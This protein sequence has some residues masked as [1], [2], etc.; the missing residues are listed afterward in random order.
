LLSFSNDLSHH[1]KYQ[2]TQ[3][4]VWF[5][6]QIKLKKIYLIIF[7]LL[8][9]SCS[10]SSD[11]GVASLSN[12]TT[13]TSVIAEED[14]PIVLTQCLNEEM[15]YNIATPF[16]IEDLKST[17][18]QLSNSKDE[19]KQLREDVDYCISKYNLWLESSS[20]NP[21]ELAKIYDENLELAKCL[22]EKGLIVPDPNQQEPKVDLSGLKESKDDIMP[23]LQECG[24][25]K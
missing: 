2:A 15:A 11:Y 1:K 9:N 10:T 22:R 18:S 23:L 13:T 16:D 19:E 4:F 6:K 5:E 20:L 24:W 21:E 3:A 7:T 14:Y 8:F 25:Q 12:D 17:I